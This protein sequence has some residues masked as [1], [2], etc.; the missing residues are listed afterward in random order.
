MHYGIVRSLHEFARISS[1]HA[2]EGF[3]EISQPDL[4]LILPLSSH[5][6]LED[7]T[8]VDMEICQACCLILEEAKQTENINEPK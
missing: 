2:C 1:G 7:G 4:T 3:T 6:V 5:T 8:S